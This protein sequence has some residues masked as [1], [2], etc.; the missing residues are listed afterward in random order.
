MLETNMP[1]KNLYFKECVV[2]VTVS[3]CY[4]ITTVCG[5]ELLFYE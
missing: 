4:I 3:V 5:G 2:G 1:I